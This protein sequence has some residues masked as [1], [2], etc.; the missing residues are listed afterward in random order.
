MDTED[1]LL[2]EK[3][4]STTISRAITTALQKKINVI[5]DLYKKYQE[6]IDIKQKQLEDSILKFSDRITERQDKLENRMYYLE[7][8]FDRVEQKIDFLLNFVQNKYLDS[9]SINTYQNIVPTMN[10]IPLINSQTPL[11]QNHSQNNLNTYI[12]PQT[13]VQQYTNMP[14]LFKKD[15]SSSDQ[16]MDCLKDIPSPHMIKRTT[17]YSNQPVVE[18]KNNEIKN[19][20]SDIKNDRKQERKK[21]FSSHDSETIDIEKSISS[22]RA[23]KKKEEKSNLK[24][25]NPTNFVNS[26][27]EV[28]HEK[29]DSIDENTIKN[30]L[31]LNSIEGEI[32]LFKK[33]YI[34]GIPKEYYPIRHIKKKFQYWFE[35]HMKDDNGS[36]LIDTI[37]KNIELLYFKVNIDYDDNPDQFIKNQEYI[38]TISEQKFKDKFLVKIINIIDH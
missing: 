18:S 13:N 21:S 24:K 27:K 29:F 3:K 28:K 33:M 23:T 26:F 14:S 11:I 4:T 1:L 37:I 16:L 12:Q 19:L 15:K 31:N 35:G 32:L 10:H 22:I 7:T 9:S 25:H 36:Y 30:C 6:K 38:F 2:D 34:D 17:S 5:E 20:I 8:K